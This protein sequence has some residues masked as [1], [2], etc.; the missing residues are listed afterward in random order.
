M[1]R[2]QSKAN[3]ANSGGTPFVTFPRMPFLKVKSM[4]DHAVQQGIENVFST[5]GM[6]ATQAVNILESSYNRPSAVYRPKLTLDGNSWIALYGDDLQVGCSG[7]GD[8][9]D[10]A[11]W[12]FDKNWHKK[13]GT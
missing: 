7:H 5:A 3:L 2:G 11:M 4:S 9:P 1:Y 6:L 13:V 8:S 10:A 12:D